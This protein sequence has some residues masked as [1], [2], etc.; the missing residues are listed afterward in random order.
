MRADAQEERALHLLRLAK[1]LGKM[2]YVHRMD[3]DSPG[4]TAPN[5]PKQPKT[6]LSRLETALVSPSPGVTLGELAKSLGKMTPRHRMETTMKHTTLDRV[7]PFR[8]WI[9]V[10]RR[11]GWTK[12]DHESSAKWYAS[13]ADIL[14]TAH[15]ALVETAERLYGEDGPLISAGLREHW[16]EY[17][18]N[19]IRDAAQR[20]TDLRDLV[21][22]HWRAAGKRSATLPQR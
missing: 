1:S 3:T 15:C 18:K 9:A 19:P 5:T 4:A 8:T 17:V 22:F 10:Y 7:M 20:S 11:D 21:A 14:R 6:A 16:P 2:G 13:Q 12:A